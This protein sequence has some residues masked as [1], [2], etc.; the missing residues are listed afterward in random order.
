MNI[1]VLGASSLIGS[2]IYNNLKNESL[3]P[4]FGT[5]FSSGYNFLE[6]LDASNKTELN[7]FLERRKP[8]VVINSIGMPG[9]E[10]CSRQPELAKILN[11]RIVGEI[12]EWCAKNNSLLVHL[13]TVAVHDGK[14]AGAYTEHDAPS[15]LEGNLY[16]N[17]KVDA[18][19]LVSEIPKHIILRIGDTYGLHAFESAK[20]GGSIFKWAY[21]TLKAGKELPAFSGLRT[22]ETF[23]EDIG[24]SIRILLKQNY[25]GILNIGGPE[26]QVADFFEMMKDTFSL[27][28]KI[29]IKSLP[30]N[31]QANKLIDTT[32][33]KSLGIVPIEIKAGLFLSSLSVRANYFYSESS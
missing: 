10:A 15:R 4:V 2:H 32:L 11:T 6:K 17:T 12:S 1:A 3:N 21:E 28:G 27:P 33:M 30:S 14:K 25:R 20:L 22:N 18:E 7:D 8:D 5:K 13:S 26:I 24:R 16:N 19:A 9:K 29:V 31:Y 23:L